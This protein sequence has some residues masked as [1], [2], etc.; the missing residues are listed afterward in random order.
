M[1]VSKLV[2]DTNTYPS[3][4]IF[5]VVFVDC[6][7]PGSPP[8]PV[9]ITFFTRFAQT[10][11]EDVADLSKQVADFCKVAQIPEDSVRDVFYIGAP[12]S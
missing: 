6:S 8:P 5:E 4:A 9:E 11:E 3:E 2:G 12:K 7:V 10:P 1:L